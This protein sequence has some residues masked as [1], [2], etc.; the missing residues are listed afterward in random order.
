MDW[1]YEDDGVRNGPIGETEILSLYNDQK[2]NDTTMVWNETFNN[3]WKPLLQAGVALPVR[4]NRLPPPLPLRST[5]QS[6]TSDSSPSR[7]E[8]N[9]FLNSST[10]NEIVDKNFDRYKV[11]WERIFSKS[12]ERLDKTYKQI[13]WNWSAF[14]CHSAWFFY[15]KLYVSGSILLIAEVLL[16]SIEPI[17]QLIIGVIGGIIGNGIYL[18]RVFLIYKNA[19][20]IEDNNTRQKT[21]L[22]Q[23]HTSFSF[24]L[25][26]L[27]VLIISSVG[28]SKFSSIIGE[29]EI[30]CS[31]TKTVNLVKQIVKDK[32]KN[33]NLGILLNLE[34]TF[35]SVNSIRTNSTT[36]K[37][38]QCGAELGFIVTFNE[39]M[40][41]AGNPAVK[42]G[43][44]E[45]IRQNVTYTSQYTDKKDIY[46][47]VRGL[48]FNVR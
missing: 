4:P 24:S 34:K 25:A 21:I 32:M 27:A 37:L 43:I 1:Y 28:L 15:R 29:D 7:L 44:E 6:T 14:V 22:K 30:A 35:V 33:E 12:G 9:D 23:G 48:N 26:S 3:E 8:F 45:K 18:R 20:S 19:R 10:T 40:P 39:N 2:I 41:G 46:V 13:S 42:T 16:F 5:S 38:N 47:T 36:S 31:S 11:Q 17:L